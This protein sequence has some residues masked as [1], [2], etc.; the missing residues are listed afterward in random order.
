MI[1]PPLPHLTGNRKQV[2]H[3][4]LSLQEQ[5]M[6]TMLK[7]VAVFIFL[8]SLYLSKNNYPVRL[9][10]TFDFWFSLCVIVL[11]FGVSIYLFVVGVKYRDN[12][13]PGLAA[14]ALKSGVI[15]KVS[16]TSVKKQHQVNPLFLTLIC[17]ICFLFEGFIGVRAY[18]FAPRGLH[19]L[20]DSLLFMGFC[21]LAA[22]IGSIW[23]FQWWLQQRKEDRT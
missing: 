18:F 13:V 15:D 10:A 7:G 23:C 14:P 8:L 17:F 2:D 9:Q 20:L 6:R 1:E 5:K 4:P 16:A 19:L 11:L 22:L 3:T 12:V 21:T